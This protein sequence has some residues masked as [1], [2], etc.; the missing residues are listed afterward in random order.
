MNYAN[1]MLSHV[2]RNWFV[3]SFACSFVH[4][5]VTG[6]V[7]GTY[8]VAVDCRMEHLLGRPGS[9]T[10]GPEQSRAA[11]VDGVRM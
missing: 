6:G 8:M 4:C 3:C 11:V 7:V 9:L 1:V 2:V 5:Q 10:C